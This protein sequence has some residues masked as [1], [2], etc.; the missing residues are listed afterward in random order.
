[1]SMGIG[2]AG[3][4][5]S[6]TNDRIIYRYYNYDLNSPVNRNDKKLMD[7]EISIDKSVFESRS[8]DVAGLLKSGAVVITNSANSW[9]VI[10]GYDRIA[11]SLCRKIF[12]EYKRS[13][14]IPENVGYHV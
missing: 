13:G 11:L 9:C 8:C 10:E 1:M 12:E 4:V 5:F 14:M 3:K 6:E 2:G 7:G